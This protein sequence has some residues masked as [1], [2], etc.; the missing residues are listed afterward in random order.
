MRRMQQE[1][2]IVKESVKKIEA[3]VQ[4]ANVTLKDVLDEIQSQREE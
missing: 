2:M 1:I 4:E 3:E